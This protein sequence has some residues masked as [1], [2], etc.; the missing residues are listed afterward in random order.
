MSCAWRTIAGVGV[1]ALLAGCFAGGPAAGP[2]RHQWRPDGR[3]GI[4][5]INGNR[6]RPVGDGRLACVTA[7]GHRWGMKTDLCGRSDGLLEALMKAG[8]RVRDGRWC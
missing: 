3:G 7:D 4:V 5:D 1:A 8:V 6:C 2:D